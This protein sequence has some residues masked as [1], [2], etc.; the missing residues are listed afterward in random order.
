[1][2]NRNYNSIFDV[3]K[4]IYELEALPTLQKKITYWVKLTGE[5]PQEREENQLTHQQKN[6]IGDSKNKSEQVLLTLPWI[7]EHY[8]HFIAKSFI[9][10][11]DERLTYCNSNNDKLDVLT[12][13]LNI[14]KHNV[15]NKRSIYYEGYLG[16]KRRI[17]SYSFLTEYN[18]FLNKKFGYAYHNK[19]ME[20]RSYYLVEKEIINRLESIKKTVSPT[21]V[22]KYKLSI[23]GRAGEI[24]LRQLEINEE[25]NEELAS[26]KRKSKKQPTPVTEPEFT[27]FDELF[28]DEMKEQP[29][30]IEQCYQALRDE[31]VIADNNNYIAG[32]KA[33]FIVWHFALTKNGL[34]KKRLKKKHNETVVQLLN[35]KFPGL[36]LWL[37]SIREKHT[38]TMNKYLPIFTAY[39]PHHPTISTYH[40]K[41]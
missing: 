4:V 32:T 10:N 30:L 2:E 27:D 28:T 11:L 15:S 33:I 29:A 40:N 39:L 20:G 26:K 8:N 9:K 1:M 31:E 41:K 3:T 18:E 14:I 13:E 23:G 17:N 21:L 5:H 6:I 12:E 24:A 37:S 7:L 38:S 19:Y 35:N 25:I 36:N 34:L 16:E 22:N